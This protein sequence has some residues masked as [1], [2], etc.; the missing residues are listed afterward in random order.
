MTTINQIDPEQV[1]EL[2]QAGSVALLDVRTDPEVA[3]GLIA[4]A[5]H[6]PLNQLP[7]RYQELDPNVLLVVY[8][9]SGARSAQACAWLAERGTDVRT[10]PEEQRFA[11]E[12]RGKGKRGGLRVIYYWWN[13]GSQFCLFTVYDKNELSDLTPLQRK[14]LK[15]MIKKELEAR[16]KR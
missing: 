15:E 7:G 4:G 10:L 1:E 16:R 9:Q 6:I 5:N 14:A 8:C 12:R 13:T 3:R 11:D 2:R